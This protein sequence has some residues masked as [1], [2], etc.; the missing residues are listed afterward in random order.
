MLS[1]KRERLVRLFSAVLF[2]LMVSVHED[3]IE[4]LCGP[5]QE[6]KWGSWFGGLSGPCIMV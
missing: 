5:A 6:E 3:V 2:V 4:G 1:L